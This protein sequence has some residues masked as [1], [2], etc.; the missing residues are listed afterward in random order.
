VDR[1][2]WIGITGQGK[3]GEYGG[4]RVEEDKDE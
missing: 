3:V 4:E 1:G 2:D